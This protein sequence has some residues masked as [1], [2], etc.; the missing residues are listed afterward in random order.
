MGMQSGLL[1]AAS[2]VMEYWPYLRSIRDNFWLF[3]NMSM[4]WLEYALR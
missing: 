1:I 3:D 2:Y 4:T